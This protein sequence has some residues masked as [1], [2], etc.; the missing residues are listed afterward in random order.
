M[1]KKPETAKPETIVETSTAVIESAASV[2]TVKKGGLKMRVVKRITLPTLNPSVGVP[3]FVRFDSAIRVSDYKDPD[4]RKAEEKPADIAE[5]TDMETGAVF[6]LLVS[7][8]IKENLHRQYPDDTYKGRI[9]AIQK[10]P[11]R[12]NKR[13][14]DW[15]IAEVEINE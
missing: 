5:I 2:A 7:S 3:M 10:L 9:F 4:P 13:Y 12:P 11:K 1:A 8:V 14:H 6:L 15:D